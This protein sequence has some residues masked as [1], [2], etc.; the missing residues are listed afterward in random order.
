MA[1]ADRIRDLRGRSGR[2]ERELAD[3]LGLTVEAY[4][5]L[6]QYDEELETTLSIAQAV[7]LARLLGTDLS[8][9]IGDS[10]GATQVRISAIRAGMAPQLDSSPGAR[11]QLED[12][13]DWDLGP[14][15]EGADQWMTVYTLDFIRSLSAAIGLNYGEVLAGLAIGP[16]AGA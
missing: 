10:A 3:L 15:L 13:I 2:T 9:M 6:E 16:G 14:F 12:L 5:D 4:C 7:T 1:I 11:E 8:Q